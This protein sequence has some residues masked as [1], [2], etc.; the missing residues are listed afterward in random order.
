MTGTRNGT[1]GATPAG[2][3]PTPW[4]ITSSPPLGITITT[5][6]IGCLGVVRNR[7]LPESALVDIVTE[8]QPADEEPLKATLRACEWAV[9]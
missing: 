6:T 7:G 5:S 9:V 8:H 1:P 4:T 2:I 3:A